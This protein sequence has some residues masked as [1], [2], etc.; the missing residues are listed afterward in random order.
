MKRLLLAMMAGMAIS[1]IAPENLGQWAADIWA[2]PLPPETDSVSVIIIREGPGAFRKASART[3][4]GTNSDGS[5][6]RNYQ[7]PDETSWAEFTRFGSLLEIRSDNAKDKKVYSVKVR[8]DRRTA[9][10]DT[11]AQGKVVSSRT[12]TPGP[13]NVIMPEYT[14][15]IRQVWRKGLR[16][17]FSFKGIAPDGSMQI[18]METRLVETNKPW[19]VGGEYEVP[20]EFQAA[21]P[22]SQ[23]YVVADF[24]L[25][26]MFSV[27]YKYHNYLVFRVTPAGLEYAGSFGGDPQKATFSFLTR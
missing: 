3:T 19:S 4:C 18:D 15:L 24:S 17:S 14:N 8:P 21:F 20:A 12:L 2:L 22:D 11:V 6:V 13:N 23:K 16:G 5:Y 25:G 7:G 9:Q 26:G 10:Y 27:L 1:A